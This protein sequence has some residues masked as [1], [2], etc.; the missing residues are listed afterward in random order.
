MKKLIYLLLLLSFSTYGF[1]FENNDTQTTKIEQA[2]E[3]NI[4]KLYAPDA[5]SVTTKSIE[6]TVINLIQSVTTPQSI[7]P[8]YKLPFNVSKSFEALYT[9]TCKVK[10]KHQNIIG[11]PFTKTDIIF[12]FHYHW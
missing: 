11:V 5:P 3:E 4:W 9:N 6:S 2:Q 8:V 12:P 1:S 7:V 10:F